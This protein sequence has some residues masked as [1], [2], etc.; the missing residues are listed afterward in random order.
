[1]GKLFRRVHYLLNRCRFDRELEN[2]MQFH[3]EMA[4]RAGATSFGNMLRLREDAREAWGWTWIDRL[5]HDMRYAGRIHWRSPGFTLT[6][7]LVLGIGI[8]V[9]VVAFSLFNLMALK[10]LPVRDPDSIVRLQRR[11]PE[12]VAGEMPYPSVAFYQAHTKTLRA[13]MT[14]FGVPAMQLEDDVQPV[15]TNFVSA[16]YFSELGTT[17]AAGRLLQPVPDGAASASPA[18]VLSFGLWQR[19]FGGDPSVIGTVIHL[20]KKPVTVIGV[21]PYAFASLGGQYSEYPVVTVTTALLYRG[22]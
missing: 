9:N 1:M 8:G 18:V 22:Q 14:V 15:T 2:D 13:V 16:N 6:A 5:V 4:E 12:I 20:N 3:R 7:V 19:R 10:P 11:S 17:P 21:T